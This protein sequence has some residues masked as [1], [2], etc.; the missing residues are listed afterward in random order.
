VV[1]AVAHRGANTLAMLSG[2]FAAAADMLE[3]DVQ[4][5]PRGRL[6]VRHGTR[7]RPLPLAWDDGR[8]RRDT[9]HPLVHGELLTAAD[10][11][12]LRLMLDVKGTDVRFAARVRA[13]LAEHGHPEVL[14]CGRHWP[15]L[16][17]LGTA[18]HVRILLSA[19]EAEEL[20]ALRRICQEG[21]MLGGAPV[22]GASLEKGLVSRDLL[23][24]LHETLEMTLAWTVLSVNEA[25][26]L[27][28]AG[29]RGITTDSLDVLQFLR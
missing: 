12:P 1:L 19:G 4:A 5:G 21:A 23:T 20:A 9:R 26:R 2:P 8:L 14:V 28:A 25:E 18:P 6:E 11:L 7:L 24:E 17:V 29:V 15:S 13:L 22:W 16:S 10:R 27:V 3:L